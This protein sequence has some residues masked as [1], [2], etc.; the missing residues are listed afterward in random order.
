ME[1]FKWDK[2]MFEE[3]ADYMYYTSEEHMVEVLKQEIF[4]NTIIDT[5]LQ[6]HNVKGPILNNKI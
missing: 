5:L 6:G 3:L 1:N 4:E 2:E